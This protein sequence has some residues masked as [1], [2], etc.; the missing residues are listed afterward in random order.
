MQSLEEITQSQMR[1]DATMDQYSATLTS[2][3]D[4]KPRGIDWIWD[5]WLPAGKLTILAGDGGTGKTTLLLGL[6][7][8]LTS[9]GYWP[10]GSKCQESGNVLIWSSEDDPADTLVPR[11][12]AMHA[13]LNKIHFISG[14]INE[15]GEQE[16]F[17]PAMDMPLLKAKAYAI[18]GVKLMMLDP[19]VSA[20]KGDSHKANDTRRSLQPV[21]DFAMEMKAAVVGI[22]HFSKGSKGST[23]AERVIGSQAFTALARMVW[24]AA[25]QEDGSDRVLAR[26]KSNISIDDGGISY[27][28]EESTV[29]D[30]EARPITTTRVS[31]GGPVEGTAREILG[32]VEA[33][34]TDDPGKSAF[35]EVKEILFDILGKGPLPF[36]TVEAEIKAAGQ[37]MVTAKRVKAKFNIKSRRGLESLGE[38]VKLWYW[39]PSEEADISAIVPRISRVS[40]IPDDTLDPLAG[41]PLSTPFQARV[42]RGSSKT[43]DTLDSHDIVELT[44][45]I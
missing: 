21:V 6:I 3:A 33:D 36:K 30:D 23:P 25:K 12:M 32:T 41:E 10:D 42:S 13:N 24:V 28:I 19:I 43:P 34:E 26:A 39:E 22:S 37:S 2:A 35:D 7:A 14:R 4:I 1:I 20:V 16:P 38:D 5:Q 8:A 11:L 45:E 18:G 29:S 17:D 40:T 15:K 44:G 31:W 9:K 27:C